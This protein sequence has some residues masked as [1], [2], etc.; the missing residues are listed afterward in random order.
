M[1]KVLINLMKEN[2]VTVKEIQ[3]AVASRGY[4]S[5]DTPIDKYD[6]DFITI[7]L[8]GAWDKVL[9]IIKDIHDKALLPNSAI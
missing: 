1:V 8:V 7:A 4:Y 3:Q 2:N 6:P 9:D 5:L